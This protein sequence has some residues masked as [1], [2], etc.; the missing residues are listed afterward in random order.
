MDVMRCDVF[1]QIFKLKP[2]D[3]PTIYDMV[4]VDVM[5]TGQVTYC[6]MYLCSRFCDLIPLASNTGLACLM[7]PAGDHT[8][9]MYTFAEDA[10][11]VRVGCVCVCG[12]HFLYV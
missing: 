4:A 3:L 12:D 2:N 5:C 6:C 8:P 11:G 7:S 9:A 10:S 1:P